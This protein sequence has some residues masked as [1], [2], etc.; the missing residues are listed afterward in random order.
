MIKLQ[1]YSTRPACLEAL[2]IV[3]RQFRNLETVVPPARWVPW[4]DGHNWRYVEQLPEQLLIQKL[5]RQITG[6]QTTD[7]LLMSGNLQEVGVLYRMLDE[8]HEDVCFICLGMRTGKWTPQHDEYVRY[9][10]SEDET[11]RQP[12]VRRRSIRAYVNRA[13]GQPDPSRADSVGREIHKTYSDYAH[14][15]SAPIMGMVHGPP[16]RFDLDGIHDAGARFP[17]IEQ[18]PAYFYRCLVSA[19]M[20]A[21]VVLPDRERLLAYQEI[22]EF[23]TRHRALLF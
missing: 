22:K 10:W 4:N 12:P 19:S 17:Y 15:R 18:N 13:L 14:A 9:F 21:N 1:D 3:R 5:A 7:L 23:E 8:I 11:D 20:I 16:A 2:E 6:A